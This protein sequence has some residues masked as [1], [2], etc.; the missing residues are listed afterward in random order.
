MNQA[1]PTP[2][3]ALGGV[4]RPLGSAGFTLLELMI[5]L[6]VA[7]LLVAMILSIFGR[8]SLGYRT[9]QQVAQ[10][11]SLLGAA[12]TRITDD[13]KQAG[14]Q[15][16]EGFF[17]GNDTSLHQPIVITNSATGPDTIAAFY[18]DATAQA[19]ITAFTGAATTASPLSAATI[20]SNAATSSQVTNTVPFAVGDV[21]VLVNST[22]ITGVVNPTTDAKLVQYRACTLAITAITGTTPATITFGQVTPWG[23][24]ANVHCA[25]V[26]AGHTTSNPT[27]MYRFVGRGYRIDPT[28]TADGVL[29]VSPSGGL[30]NTDWQDLGYGFTDLQVASQMYEKAD[31][32]DTADPDTDP[33]R[34]WYSGPEQA[35]YTAA[36]A[37]TSPA[38]TTFGSF[39]PILQLGVSLV[40][41]TDRD[42]EGITTAATPALI[43]A[44]RTNYNQIGDRPSEAVTVN[45]IYRYTT[46]QLDLRNMGVGR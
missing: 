21:V 43:D 24:T 3:R 23:K 8:M 5:S 1:R 46:F 28:R 16:S 10:L 33:E 38:Y 7:S 19:K 6:V 13:L 39:R 32:T 17:I 12:R 36:L 37:A 26:V 15:L 42:I 18:A 25:T 27:M 9:Q 40:A 29:Q 4:G 45:R 22:T 31:T 34:D 20:D 41:R 11:Q 14:F 2:A 30:V 44:T 35:T